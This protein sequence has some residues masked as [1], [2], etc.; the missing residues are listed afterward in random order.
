V[1]KVTFIG[2]GSTVFAQN[3]T[4]DI[5]SSPALRDT[6]ELALMDIDP[7]RLRTSE[8]VASRVVD[9]LG[10]K[11]TVTATTD[12]RAAFD[13]ADCVVTMMQV[14]GYRPAA[15]ACRSRFTEA[16]AHRRRP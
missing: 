13:G 15:C 5:L 7:E 12:R 10:S 8:T 14:G 4:G 3:L 2:A 6:T 1:P 9:A 16:R 11:A